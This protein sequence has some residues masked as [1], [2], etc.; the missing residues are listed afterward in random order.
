VFSQAAIPQQMNIDPVGGHAL[1]GWLKAKPFPLM[2]PTVRPH[3]NDLV[4]LSDQVLDRELRIE[5]GAHHADSL[6]QAVAALALCGERVVLDVVWQRDLVD[7][8]EP[9]VV[10]DFFIEPPDGPLVLTLPFRHLV[11]SLRSAETR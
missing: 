5:S 3:H 1:S 11:S 9:P 8:L 7:D 10:P 2:R 4:T 6:L